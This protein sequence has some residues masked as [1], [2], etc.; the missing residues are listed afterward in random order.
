ME[1]VETKAAGRAVKVKKF[2]PRKQAEESLDDVL[3]ASLKGLEK[4][5]AG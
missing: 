1:L 2:R 3:A 5:K 4:K